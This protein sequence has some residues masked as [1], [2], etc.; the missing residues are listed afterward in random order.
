MMVDWKYSGRGMLKFMFILSIDSMFWRSL[1]PPNARAS[2]M[3]LPLVK[4]TLL[5]MYYVMRITTQRVEQMMISLL[6][7]L[8][9]F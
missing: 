5:R 2:I 1:C 9:I 4:T 3:R 6:L 7:S 8:I